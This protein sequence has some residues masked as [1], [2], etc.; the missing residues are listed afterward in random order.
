M[1]SSSRRG[2]LSRAMSSAACCCTTAGSRSKAFVMISPLRGSGARPR[3]AVNDRDQDFFDALFRDG[4]GIEQPLQEHA[5]DE[6]DAERV[7]LLH[8]QGEFDTEAFG[9]IFD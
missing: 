7:H 9:Q 8:R 3:Q 6:R 2:R 5:A 4:A 1:A